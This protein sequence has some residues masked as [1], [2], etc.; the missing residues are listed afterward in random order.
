MHT[1]EPDVQTPEKKTAPR[2]QRRTR[3]PHWEQ[4][5]ELPPVK[6]EIIINVGDTET[7]IAVLEDGKLVEL[8]YERPDAVKMAGNVYKGVVE[9]VLPG[10]QAAFVHIGE[11]RTAF[12]HASDISKM[13]DDEYESELED[14]SEPKRDLIRKEKHTAIEEVVKKNQII[15]VQ[16][17]KE[18]LGAKGGRITTNVSLP[19]RFVVLV[20]DDSHVRVSKRIS[21]WAERRR[22]KTLLEPLRPKGCGLIA[23]TEAEGGTEKDFK[24]DIKQLV[25]TWKQVVKDFEKK[26]APVCLYRETDI[27]G[28]MMR[29]IFSEDVER[30]IVDDKKLY[31][32]M[33]AYCK[34]I[35]PELKD[36]IEL[37]EGEVPTFDLYA[38]ESEIEKMMERKVWFKRGSYLVID[39]TEAMVTIDVNTGRFVGKSNQEETILRANLQAA[40]EVAR[41]VRLR[42]LGGLII[43]DFIDMM[44]HSNRKRVYEE[45]SLAFARD[46]AKNSIATISEFGL[47]EMT[48]QR[49]RPQFMLAQTDPCPTCEGTGRVLSPETIAAKLERWFERARAATSIKRFKLVVH[50]KEA[51]YLLAD[52]EAWLKRIKKSSKSDI[53]VETDELLGPDKYR[54]VSVDDGVDL[55][56]AFHPRTSRPTP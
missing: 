26:A 41:Q 12:L 28:A 30:L 52:K 36:R 4:P 54:I 44:H 38:I 25:K 48:R 34:H 21:N 32:E 37:Y 29:D 2:P 11:E 15:L 27:T 6:K 43:V 53:T 31:K 49:I 46:H 56:D 40:Q 10:M 5:V 7:R 9:S 42:D 35:A 22:L 45:F 23:R 14:E 16:V 51:E 1:E 50:P 20:P 19:G 8:S 24:N 33:V 3:R 55:T 47:I 17:I 39:Q 18:P 13:G